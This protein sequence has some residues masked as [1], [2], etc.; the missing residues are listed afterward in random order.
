ME[1]ASFAQMSP[2]NK[3]KFLTNALQL[4]KE[5]DEFVGLIYKDD[6]VAYKIMDFFDVPDDK[7]TAIRKVVKKWG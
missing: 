2:E 7:Q 5:A 3:E 4:K 6:I 1:K